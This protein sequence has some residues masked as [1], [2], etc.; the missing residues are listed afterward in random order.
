MRGATPTYAAIEALRFVIDPP[1]FMAWSRAGVLFCAYL[2]RAGKRFSGG[3]PVEMTALLV[4]IVA[5][6]RG[7][8]MGMCMGMDMSMGMGMGMNM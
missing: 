2:D 1:F 8:G 6:A 4:G 5:C 3:P 7:L